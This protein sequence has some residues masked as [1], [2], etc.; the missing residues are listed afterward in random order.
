[1]LDLHT[2][3]EPVDALTLV[4]HL[5]QAGQL[6]ARRR[7]RRGRP[8]RRRAS[9]RSATSASTRASSA[10]TRCCA[11]SCARPTR[12]RR[13]STPTRRRRASSST[14][15]SARSS[16]SPTRT[17]ARTSARSTT[18]L[19]ASSTSSSSSPREGKAITGTPSGFEDLDTHHRRLPA[20]QPHHPGRTAVDGQVGADGQ[21]RRER[22]AR[23]PEGRRAVLARDVGGGARAA[24]HRLAR[25]R[26]RATT[27]ARARSPQTRWGK[28]M[29]ASEPARGVAAVHRRLVRPRRCSTCARRRAGSHSST[30]TASGSIL[31]DYLQLMRADG[32]D[33]QPRGAGRPDLP[34]AQDARARARGAGDRAL[35]AQP[36]RRA[37]GRQAARC[38]PTSA[39]PARSSR[40]PTS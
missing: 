28:I 33:R 11:A 31:I 12:S 29:A 37:A 21:L 19:D 22:R 16:R 26:S 35:P 34:R 24:L 3:G 20:R 32:A 10:R 38:C 40:T 14:S 2:V 36:R 23:R 39:S 17:A 6:D 7:P 1:M 4:E 8:P 25:R 30:P 13:A 5:K 9:P 15:P 18:C 27:C